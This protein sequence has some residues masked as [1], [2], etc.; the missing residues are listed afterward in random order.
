MEGSGRR[1]YGAELRQRAAELIDRGLGRKALAGRLAIPVNLAQDWSLTYKATGLPGLLTM[2]T[3]YKTYDYQTKVA[4]ARDCVDAGISRQE[5][6][7]R[8]GIVSVRTLKKWVQAYRAGG[9]AALLPK[10][11]GRPSGSGK[12]GGALSREEELE[13]RVR[14][15]EAE[16]A[17]LKKLRALR[18]AKRPTARK[19]AR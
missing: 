18:A 2:G 17:Y 8:Y 4:A 11:R 14:E 1:V 6:M 19:P 3:T 5:V 10:A 7:T 15:L 16:N 12:V 9:A 13:Q